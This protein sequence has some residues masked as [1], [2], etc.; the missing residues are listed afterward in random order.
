MGG[1]SSKKPEPKPVSKKKPLLSILAM[2]NLIV[3]KT[4]LIQRFVTKEFV[5]AITTLGAECHIVNKKVKN[6]DE[7]VEVKIKVWD[8]PGQERFKSLVLNS[9]KNTQG[10]FLVFDV[11]SQPS[12]D[13][14]Q[15]WISKVAEVQDPKTF[16]FIIIANKIDLELEGKR[17]VTKGVAQAF[18]DK[19]G[20][21]LF[22]TSAKSG[23]GVEEAFQTLIQKV[24]DRNKEKKKSNFEIQ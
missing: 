4:A 13:D 8:S 21:P 14:L 10:I 18:A 12:F 17:V 23:Q 24:Y 7:E 22:E 19:Y 3:G 15:G 1:C 9:L 5:P 20:L 6:N 11:S 2:G 16:P